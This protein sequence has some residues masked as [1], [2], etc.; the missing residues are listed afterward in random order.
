MSYI[1]NRNFP[2]NNGTPP[3]PIGYKFSGPNAATTA[4]VVM[5]ILRKWLTDGFLVRPIS[6][7]VPDVFDAGSPLQLHRCYVIYSM[8]HW[9]MAFPSLTYLASVGE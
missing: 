9:V 5:P 3:G 4:F 1:D 6:N 2:G 8:N 7:S